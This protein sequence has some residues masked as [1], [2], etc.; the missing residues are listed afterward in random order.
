MDR[1]QVTNGDIH[2]LARN[3][4]HVMQIILVL[5]VTVKIFLNFIFIAQVLSNVQGNVIRVFTFQT[6]I[7]FPVIKIVNNAQLQQLIAHHVVLICFWMMFLMYVLRV[8]SLNFMQ[9]N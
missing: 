8:V 9:I 1:V 3:V 7:V 4:V 2:V 6:R 5:I